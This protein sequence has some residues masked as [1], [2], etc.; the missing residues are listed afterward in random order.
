VLADRTALD[1]WLKRA[2]AFTAALPARPA[3]PAA[4]KARQSRKSAELLVASPLRGSG[5]VV[6][7]RK[8]RTR[9]I[10]Q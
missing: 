2:L 10:K 7:R 5:L 1:R 9:K 4:R 3:K 8:D 6:E